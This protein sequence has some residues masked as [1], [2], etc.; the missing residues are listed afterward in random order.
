MMNSL[1]GKL[2]LWIALTIAAI[3]LLGG[4]VLH[5]AVQRAMFNEFDASLK[6][7]CM[8]LALLVETDGY[9]IES[10]MTDSEWP[11]FSPSENAE[12]YQIL[13]FNGKPVESS[14]SLKDGELPIVESVADQF[15]FTNLTLPDGRSGRL[16]A[17][18]LQPH[19]DAE[20]KDPD[21]EDEVIQEKDQ[22]LYS[23]PAIYQDKPVVVAI[24][25]STEFVDA[26]MSR[27][28]WTIGILT[29]IGIGIGMILSGIVA[30]LGLSSL[31]STV[32][33]ISSIDADNLDRQLDP[34]ESPTEIQP[35]VNELNNLV[36]RLKSSFDRER[37]FSADVAHE[38]RTPIAGLKSTL[39]V[40]LSKPR[41]A[42][43]YAESMKKCLM[44]CEQTESVLE[45]ML[46]LSRVESN[47]LPMNIEPVDISNVIQTTW[48]TLE[49]QAVAKNMSVSTSL[50][51]AEIVLTDREKVRL[52]VRNLIDN[53]ICYGDQSS[54]IGI[55][56]QQRSG[57]ATIR[58]TN[59]CSDLS[60]AETEL[61]F[62]RFWRKDEARSST[63]THCGIGL[64]LSR[65][66]AELL[67][68]ELKASVN[69]NVVQ[70][71]F[72]FPAKTA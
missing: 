23:G 52:V 6:Q 30:R 63:G 15:L 41:E 61:W 26:M 28:R 69:G 5:Y 71:E 70:F 9:V 3:L 40:S 2:M 34:T 67:D 27:I 7:S 14:T 21:E 4:V 1:T 57:E 43:A 53:A 58:V 37:S 44:I 51:N 20:M 18:T 72:S 25:R 60:G 35:V 33:Q 56:A 36:G 38:L 16:A 66:V 19:F 59:Q 47:N 65:S 49:A 68:G 12:Y 13:D 39:E 42:Q 55:E 29:A 32:D 10:E 17:I 48:Q 45:N 8:S 31:H 62:Q 46:T 50:S 24:A 11:Q 54:T 64:S 22:A